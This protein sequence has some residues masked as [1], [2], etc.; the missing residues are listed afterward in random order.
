MVAGLTV[1]PITFERGGLFFTVGFQ[2]ETSLSSLRHVL[3]LEFLHQGL[4]YKVPSSSRILWP[5]P[6]PFAVL[7]KAAAVAAFIFNPKDMEQD[8]SLTCTGVHF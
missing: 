4:A 7:V 8:V 5:H 1:E 2:T 6:F 3:A